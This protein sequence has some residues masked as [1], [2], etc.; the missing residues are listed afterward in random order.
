MTPARLLRALLVGEI[1]LTVLALP[2]GFLDDRFLPLPLQ[3]YSSAQ[4]IA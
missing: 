1:A 4:P 2:F 3:A